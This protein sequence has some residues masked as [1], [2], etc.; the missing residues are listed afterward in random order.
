MPILVSDSE[1][2]SDSDDDP[3]ILGGPKPRASSKNKPEV[4]T[5]QAFSATK[6][7]RAKFRFP[8]KDP[9]DNTIQDTRNDSEKV[10]DILRMWCQVLTE[11]EQAIW[12]GIAERDLTQN[13]TL[14]SG[15]RTPKHVIDAEIKAFK[16]LNS[17][18]KQDMLAMLKTAP[19][20]HTSN[21]AKIVESA[22]QNQPSELASDPLSAQRLDNDFLVGLAHL[23]TT[24]KS[25][26]AK[27][28]PDSPN[29]DIAELLTLCNTEV[30]RIRHSTKTPR[31]L[32]HIL[33]SNHQLLFK[34]MLV[35]K[36]YRPLSKSMYTIFRRLIQCK[37]I[38]ATL[39]KKVV[40]A[41]VHNDLVAVSYT[42]LRAHET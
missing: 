37:P 6:A 10:N 18:N 34:Y 27:T 29:G 35:L 14:A 36:H 16:S 19:E 23:G 20:L 30:R 40:S 5:G 1:S 28:D 13:L 8:S 17:A 21:P 24:R 31:R 32:Q 4:L 3:E 39:V 15:L 26:V 41:L 7:T 2:D 11:D 12:N 42:H 25:T 22:Q 33:R 38:A 9:V